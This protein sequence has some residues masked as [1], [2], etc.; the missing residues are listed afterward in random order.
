VENSLNLPPGLNRERFGGEE[1]RMASFLHHYIL[2]S[3]MDSLDPGS[4]IWKE[5]YHE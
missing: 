4:I 2:E 1:S 5:V 3:R